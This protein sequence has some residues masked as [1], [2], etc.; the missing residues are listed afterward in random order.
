MSEE[1]QTLDQRNREVKN[2]LD[3]LNGQL[4]ITRQKLS[5]FLDE[6]FV[7]Q[8]R[9]KRIGED[10]APDTA[11]IDTR[12][13]ERIEQKRKE[14]LYSLVDSNTF[15]IEIQLAELTQAPDTLDANRLYNELRMDI[16][17]G[18]I[19]LAKYLEFK[20]R[21]KEKEEKKAK[22]VYLDA[23]RNDRVNLAR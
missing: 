1:S 11:H 9:K 7:H 12:T 14:I 13:L 8:D 3:Q 2:L 6:G 4:V 19:M 18:Q 16:I 15:D 10:N 23:L 22:Q 21:Q 20:N 17:H 5:P